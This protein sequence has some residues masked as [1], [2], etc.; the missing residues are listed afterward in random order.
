M[1]VTSHI[2]GPPTK[3]WFHETG[4]MCVLVTDAILRNKQTYDF[5]QHTP[6]ARKWGTYRTNILGGAVKQFG[7]GAVNRQRPTTSLCH[8]HSLY[9]TCVNTPCRYGL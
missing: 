1:N 4:T 2:T 7:P 3:G 6:A 5:T 8:I 9:P